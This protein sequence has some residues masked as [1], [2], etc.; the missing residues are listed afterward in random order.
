MIVF[1]TKRYKVAALVAVVLLVAVAASVY[2]VYQQALVAKVDRSN[3]MQVVKP[4]APED[5]TT[6][7]ISTDFFTEYRLERDRLRSE[8]MELLRDIIKNS[9]NDEV[10][11]RAQNSV[12]K[13]IM[14]K[15]KE[16]EMENL[17]KAR[18]FADALV[19]IQDEAV[20]AVVKASSLTREDVMQVAD[21]IS[22]VCGVQPE[23]ITVS[24]KP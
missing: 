16:A 1:I 18:G 21:V 22:R 20:S 24:A 17:I 5:E 3:A 7:V 19:F 2:T 6:V 14:D 4:V 9:K 10:R 12:L 23:A 11:E 13:L 8:R 15:E